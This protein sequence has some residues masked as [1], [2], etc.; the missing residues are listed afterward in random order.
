MITPWT[1]IPTNQLAVGKLW[2]PDTT[3][4][5]ARRDWALFSQPWDCN[6]PEVALGTGPTA[7]WVTK[8]QFYVNFPDS[9]NWDDTTNYDTLSMIVRLEGYVD[10]GT[11]SFRIGSLMDNVWS[12]AVTADGAYGTYRDYTVT[13]AAASDT[14]PTGRK[15]ITIQVDG[16][17]GDN[18]Y[19]RRVYAAEGPTCY[20]LFG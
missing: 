5:F 9:W 14:I 17:A 6:V 12:D 11:H 7:G 4:R 20:F 2:L 13:W 1:T 8:G 10:G 19:I 15:S 16:G 18:F 3:L